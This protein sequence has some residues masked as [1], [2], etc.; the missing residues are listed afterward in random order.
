MNL[1]LFLAAKWNKTSQSTFLLKTCASTAL[2]NHTSSSFLWTPK[3]Y[4]MGMI[5]VCNCIGSANIGF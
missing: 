3:A 2:T 5:V 1:R 4:E